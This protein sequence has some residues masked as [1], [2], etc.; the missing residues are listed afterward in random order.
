MPRQR[1][2]LPPVDDIDRTLARLKPLPPKRGIGYYSSGRG[3]DS[4]S[5]AEFRAEREKAGSTPA[6][7]G[8]YRQG[9]PTP[10]TNPMSYHPH[11]EYQDLF[12]VIG[13]HLDREDTLKAQCAIDA[14]CEAVA[15]KASDDTA[16]EYGNAHLNGYNEG[17]QT[18][19]DSCVE[20]VAFI[21]KFTEGLTP[22]SQIVL[23]WAQDRITFISYPSYDS[24]VETNPTG[25]DD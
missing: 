25:R 2:R 12:D 22:E 16:L 19:H 11:P 13:R 18:A 20:A 9:H 21:S 8:R 6:K 10:T 17:W 5:L 23:Q 15:R 3:F 4:R 24:S 1:L 7:D 14:L